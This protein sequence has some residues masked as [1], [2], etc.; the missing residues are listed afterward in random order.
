MIFFEFNPGGLLLLQKRRG[1]QTRPPGSSV[2]LVWKNDLIVFSELFFS[3]VAGGL[4]WLFFSIRLIA[5]RPV[6]HSGGMYNSR[7]KYRFVYTRR[8]QLG[9]DISC[10]LKFLAIT[11]F[12]YWSASWNLCLIKIE[13]LNFWGPGNC[14]RLAVDGCTLGSNSKQREKPLRRTAPKKV[15][16]GEMNQFS[17]TTVRWDSRVVEMSGGGCG[18]K[19]VTTCSIGGTVITGMKAGGSAMSCSAAFC[20]RFEERRPLRW[21]QEQWQEELSLPPVL[22]MVVSFGVSMWMLFTKVLAHRWQAKTVFAV[23]K[24]KMHRKMM[25]SILWMPVFMANINNMKTRGEAS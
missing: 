25:V 13:N 4:S 20:R 9:Y 11:G 19:N 2:G 22:L 8:L 21:M 3:P 5:K 7:M 12:R 17:I 1:G 6:H 14:W 18:L 23:V 15:S 24:Q 16:E 10:K